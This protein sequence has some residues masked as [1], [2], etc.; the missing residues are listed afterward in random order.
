MDSGIYSITNKINRK[1]YIGST[2]NFDRRKREHFDLLTKDEHWNIKL[3]R[4]YN[5]NGS[6]VFIF[7][8]I[9]LCDYSKDLIIVNE[10]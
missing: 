1:R 7:E 4:S 9:E 2:K 6:G 3:Q 8:I 5:K 10:P